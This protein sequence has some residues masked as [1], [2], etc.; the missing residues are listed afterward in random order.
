MNSVRLFAGALSL[1][2]TA[3]GATTTT[4]NTNPPLSPTNAVN[5]ISVSPEAI[6]KVVIEVRNRNWSNATVFLN[7]RQ[8]GLVNGPNG[9]QL[10]VVSRSDVTDGIVNLKAHFVGGDDFV[11]RTVQVRRGS[12]ILLVLNALVQASDVFEQ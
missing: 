3:C 4:T 12:K 5:M 9:D 1:L 10:Y 8:L 11:A 2:S 7:G 6:A